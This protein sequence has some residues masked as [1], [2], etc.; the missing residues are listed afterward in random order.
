MAAGELEKGSGG[1]GR[2]LV[3]WRLEI[4]PQSYLPCAVSADAGHLT[5]ARAKHAGVNAAEGMA[6]EGVEQVDAELRL[7][8]LAHAEGFTQTDVFVAPPRIAD[9]EREGRRAEREGFMIND[10]PGRD[11]GVSGH[12]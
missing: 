10:Q 7:H 11:V 4:Q 6:V 2:F 9:V 3:D 5:E 8:A 1:V 12:A